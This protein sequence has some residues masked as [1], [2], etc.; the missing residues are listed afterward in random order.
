MPLAQTG[1]RLCHRRFTASTA[2]KLIDNC[3]SA[4]VFCGW[5]VESTVTGG[6]RLQG[7]SPQGLNIFLY[8]RDLGH[9]AGILVGYPYTVTFT[10][11]TIDGVFT[12]LDQ[13]VGIDATK[14][15]Q[16]VAGP[17]QI[18]LS[19]VGVT[20][21]GGGS[22]MCGGIPFVPFAA[23]CGGQIPALSTNQCFWSMG[24]FGSGKPARNN[25][26]TQDNQHQCE[27]LWNDQYMTDGYGL[28]SL[29]IACIVPAPN[30]QSGFNYPSPAIWYNG[31][32]YRYEPLLCWGLQRFYTPKVRAQIW[33]ACVFSKT[34]ALDTRQNVDV[35][36]ASY[37]WLNW[38]SPAGFVY[39]SLNLMIP[40]KE[41]GDGNYSF[42]AT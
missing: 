5:V 14:T 27:A 38:T 32:F 16:I 39:G 3:V 18:F 25:L 37:S 31:D 35:E 4:L 15:Y 26:I 40:S 20:N 10:F 41:F 6:Y 13:E 22:N 24:D 28:Y 42:I 23:T 1:A 7:V 19:M 9:S 36:G 11:Q 21:D 34:F 8:I 2:A 30:I 33:D 12:G 29:R 17:C